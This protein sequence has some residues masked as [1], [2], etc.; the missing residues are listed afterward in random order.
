M[1][2]RLRL[3]LDSFYPPGIS[4]VEISDF[5]QYHLEKIN[6]KDGMGLCIPYS[7]GPKPIYRGRLEKRSIKTLS[8]NPQTMFISRLPI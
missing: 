6:P 2:R 8:I 4:I 1:D 7:S 3:L 5:D